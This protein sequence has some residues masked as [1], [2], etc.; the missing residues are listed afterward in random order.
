MT[1][2]QIMAIALAVCIGCSIVLVVWFFY[3]RAK[4]RERN[5]FDGVDLS[6]KQLDQLV[7]QF[8]EEQRWG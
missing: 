2:L 1:I 7:K 3:E 6:D 4:Y 8:A 5:D